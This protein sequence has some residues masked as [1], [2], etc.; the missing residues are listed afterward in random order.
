MLSLFALSAGFAAVS[1][2]PSNLFSGFEDPTI[3]CSAGGHATCVQGVIPVAA[4]AMNT[5]LNFPAG[6]PANQS[7]VTETIVEFLQTNTPLPA[8]VE[9]AKVKVSG[10][11]KIG[12][13]LCYPVGQS[14]NASLVQILTHG[15]G[16]DKSY[17][18][19]YSASYSYQDAAAVAG[20]TTFAY[21][22]LGIGASDHPNPIEVVQAQ[23]EVS[24]AHS[25][26][27]NTSPLHALERG[28]RAR[29]LCSYLLRDHQFCTIPNKK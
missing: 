24:I 2:A 6:F 20:Y 26:V 28:A 25:L 15:V 19:F 5:Q 13:K 18:D 12:A 23:L 14:P 11:Y 29:S 16:F 21:D 8:Q 27:C 17:W 22:R 3:V 10:V 4:S 9:A 7:V 1:A